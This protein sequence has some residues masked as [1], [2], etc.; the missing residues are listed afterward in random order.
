MQREMP[1]S[2]VSVFSEAED[3]ETAL[4]QQG[5]LGMLVTGRDPFRAHLTQVALHRL[6]LS[7]I[8]EKL[9][10]IAFLTV[11]ADMV[12]VTFAIGKRLSPLWAGVDTRANEIVTLGP[13]ERLQARTSGASQWGMLG[14]PENDLLEYGRIMIGAHFATPPGITRWRSPSAAIRELRDL[15]RAA[16][17]TAET[18]PDRLADDETAHG[19][20]QQVIHALIE[21]LFAGPAEEKSPA[22][23]HH[24]NLL[25]RFE[26]LLRVG[27]SRSL[28]DICAEL[29]ISERLLRDCC[30]SHLGI[31]PA[32]YRRRRAM[33]Q[34]NR[35]LRIGNPKTSTVA[36][37]AKRQGF[38]SLGRFA[39]DY[40]AV[41]AELPSD[42]LR[43]SNGIAPIS[44]RRPRV[45]IS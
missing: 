16:I 14:I 32:D 7:A 21:C 15:F 29:G 27:P 33:Q 42:T 36:E 8:E 11:P 12:L 31:S 44:L 43:L 38:K 28:P 10:R 6:R 34:I 24:R 22:A 30:R 17:R 1:G 5:C 2:V 9:A 23:K 19:L 41:Y 45:K 18:R 40:R 26:D 3:F 39:G 20:E 13:G 4:R 25:A 35:E 37:I